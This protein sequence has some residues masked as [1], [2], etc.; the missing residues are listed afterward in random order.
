MKITSD[1]DHPAKIGCRII[2]ALLS[3]TISSCKGNFSE[4][5]QNVVSEG[6]QIIVEADRFK[7]ALKD[8]YTILTIINPWQGAE[9]IEQQ[10]LLI[11]RGDPI[12]DDA[13][14]SKVIFVPLKKLVCMSV[15]HVAM[16]AALGE[17]ETI[18]GVSGLGLIYSDKVIGE[19]KRGLVSDVG[20]E[21]SLNKELILDISPD[22]LMIYGIE[23]ESAGYIG[24]FKELG[25]RVLFNA[26]YLENDPL[27]KAE[28]IKL[29]G[30]LYCKENLADSI[31]KSETEAYNSLKMLIKRNIINKP[32]VL[33]GLPYRDTWYISPGN[34]YIS[35]LISDAGGEY[36]WHDTESA[37]SMPMGIENVYMRALTAD[38]WLNTGTVNTKGDISAIDDRLSAIP[39]FKSGNIYNN[40]KR[41]TSS[42]GNDYWENGTL[43]PHLVLN[44]I[45]SILHPELFPDSELFFYRRIN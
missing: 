16:V 17:A 35:N 22:V 24:K 29:F 45:A 26:D 39:C 6:E 2:I 18:S 5:K 32:K 14:S 27:K 3:I 36:L 30:A 21:A 43:F 10:Y 4:R 15:T 44:D 34:S 42:G 11:K 7:L 13:D 12:P 33:L 38:V 31:F 25:I 9:D 23:S 1:I 8:G 20:Y 28:W 40:N 37:L 41:I 19:I